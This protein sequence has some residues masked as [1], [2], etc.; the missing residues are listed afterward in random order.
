[1]T[2]LGREEKRN[3]V[4]FVVGFLAFILFFVGLCVCC[5]VSQA[6]EIEKW[7]T[8]A[9]KI[10]RMAEIK[11]IHEKLIY[12]CVRIAGAYG[13][14]SG[15]VLYSK[16]ETDEK[17]STYVLTNYHVIRSAVTLSEQWNSDLGK[18]VK[19]EKRS[20]VHVEVFQYQDLSIPVGTLKVEA[21]III[22]SEEYDL[23]LLKLRYDKRIEFT[24]NLANPEPDYYLSDRTIAVGCSLLFPP[25]LTSGEITRVNLLVNSL[26]YDMST[27]QIIF[28]NSGGAMYL[29]KTGEFIGVPFAVPGV[30]INWTTSIPVT[31]MGVFIPAS[32]VYEW[33]EK[34][35]YDFI[36]D[37]D[38]IEKACLEEREEELKKKREKN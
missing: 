2:Q 5:R 10:D 15:T 17:Y 19:T 34:E 4:L 7:N 12:P 20:V 8:V 18:N 13:G 38:K 35:H 25:I 22:Y 14:G 16:L 9:P 33:L 21:D 31:H 26:Y 6:E 29:A 24:A 36:Y 37:K 30:R 1:M 11:A 3:F 27:S 23:A 28:G 32:R